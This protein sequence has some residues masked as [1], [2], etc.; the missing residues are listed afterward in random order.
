M[1]FYLLTH[2]Q[3]AVS[4][5]PVYQNSLARALVACIHKVRTQIF[6]KAQAISQASP[7]SCTCM[8]KECLYTFAM[9]YKPHQ[10]RFVVSL[11]KLLIS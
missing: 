1:K 8:F 10:R 7:D 9:M 4:D 5:K 3:A 11:C 2:M 6:D